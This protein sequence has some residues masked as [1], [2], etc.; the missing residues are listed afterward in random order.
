MCSARYLV[1][2]SIHVKFH[3]NITNG[4]KVM[5]RTEYMVHGRNG[6]V[7]CS[8]GNNSVSRQIRV[9]AHVFCTLSHSGLH[10]CEVS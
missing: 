7:Q 3:E 6:Y 2:L 9:I 1:M 5:E 10:W 8:K 4:I